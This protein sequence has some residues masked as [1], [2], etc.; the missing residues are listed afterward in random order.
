MGR[1]VTIKTA[2]G[3]VAECCV[4]PSLPAELPEKAK[5]MAW[6]WE[7]NHTTKRMKPF[8]ITY[9]QSNWS[10]RGL[11]GFS[12]HKWWLPQRPE[13][14]VG[15]NRWWLTGKF[16]GKTPG[17]IREVP[18][19][20]VL[21]KCRMTENESNSI[22]VR[23]EEGWVFKSSEKLKWQ[24]WVLA[25]AA[26]CRQLKGELQLQAQESKITITWEHLCQEV[27]LH[28]CSPTN[29]K[30]NRMRKMQVWKGPR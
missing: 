23:R 11:H 17:R 30:D 7:E 13:I 25:L 20:I 27:W 8:S 26:A 29:A 10:L 2:A 6:K 28:Y 18:M 3:C 22:T 12:A 15:G 14:R 4:L 1:V 5:T 19:D 21:G 9:L 24:A 16:Q